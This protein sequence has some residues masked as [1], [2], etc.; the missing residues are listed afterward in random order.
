MSLR[1]T[2]IL[3]PV[4]TAHRNFQPGEPPAIS[5]FSNG[6]FH[7]ILQ[8]A[9]SQKILILGTG[10][11]AWRVAGLVQAASPHHSTVVGLVRDSEQNGHSGQASVLG[12]L[13][14][15]EEI[16]SKARPDRII[17]AL[18]ERRGRMPVREL[19]HFRANG[20]LIEDGIQA[21]ERLA[22]K[23]AIE[24]LSPSYLIFSQ[25]FDRPKWQMILRRIVS[26]TVAVVGLVV[27]APLMAMIALAIKLDSRGPVLFVQERVGL[28]G[29]IFR[30]L[31]FRTMRPAP[32]NPD[33]ASVWNRDD[34]ARITRVGKWLREFHLDEMPQFINILRGDM[35]LVGPR[36]EMAA[37]VQTM[38]EQIP[39][40]AM[41][42]M[43][44]P[45]L[46]G[47]AQV[48]NGYAVAQEEVTEKM[49]Y[50]LYYMKRMSPWLDLWILGATVV[51]VV[52]SL[53]AHDDR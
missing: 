25:D 6:V 14:E 31:K 8:L 39:Y 20:I 2:S 3:Q 37:N 27:F 41:R 13:E 35:D 42:G 7:P 15:L 16:V 29:R 47:W 22:Q 21:Y 50:D 51:K 17:V 9:R 43:V 1:A 49:R 10:P 23:L 26:L 36:P 44:R 40:Y 34:L 12:P 30:L 45:G 28:G 5:K 48:K 38:S 33:N 18:T 46:T 32:T 4:E 11:L 52:R 24:N 19:L 53:R